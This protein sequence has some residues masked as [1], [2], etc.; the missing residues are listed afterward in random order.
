VLHRRLDALSRTCPDD[1][2]WRRMGMFWALQRLL[3]TDVVFEPLVAGHA[4]VRDFS[5]MPRSSNMDEAVLE[6]LTNSM[7]WLSN[8]PVVKTPGNLSMDLS[9]ASGA[10]KLT[11]AV[12]LRGVGLLCSA[13]GLLECK[14]TCRAMFHR[15][16]VQAWSSN[17]P[18]CEVSTLRGDL[19]P[20]MTLNHAAVPTHEELPPGQQRRYARA[21]AEA[22]RHWACDS[23]GCDTAR[24]LLHTLTPMVPGGRR[25]VG[26]G[27]NFR[28]PDPLAPMLTAYRYGSRNLVPPQD[29]GEKGWELAKQA[30]PELMPTLLSSDEAYHFLGPIQKAVII[31]VTR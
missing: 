18:P 28:F 29:V 2:S 9:S 14:E 19:L 25:G 26:V 4:C 6:A 1:A 7:R 23:K 17:V 22:E 30:Y 15:W 12:Y 5:C 20:V 10:A 16:A 11:V 13:Y 3:R 24:E 31:E 8:S 21:L 27:L